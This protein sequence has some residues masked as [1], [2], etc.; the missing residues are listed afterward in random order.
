M[1][2]GDIRDADVIKIHER[3][4]KVTLLKC[5]D[6]ENKPLS[7]LVQRIKVDL[8]DQ[9]VDIFDH[10]NSEKQQLLYFKERFAAVDHPQ[11]P[12]WEELSE[13]LRGLG[14]SE[15]IGFGP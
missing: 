10:Q 2:N 15:D 9:T 1:L 8:S 14:L 7:D 12:E 5:D 3:S 4:G 13:K 6:F 11:R